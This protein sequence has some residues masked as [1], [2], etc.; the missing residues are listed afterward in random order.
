MNNI[1][2]KGFRSKN[3]QLDVVTNQRVEEVQQEG[4]EIGVLSILTQSSPLLLFQ[5]PDY[6]VVLLLL[7]SGDEG[8]VL[9][10]CRHQN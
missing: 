3:V 4:C 7:S 6:L 8:Y 1:Y 2:T 5:Q 9:A 10:S